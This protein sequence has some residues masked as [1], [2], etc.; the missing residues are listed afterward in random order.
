VKCFVRERLIA[1]RKF[2]FNEALPV[3]IRIFLLNKTKPILVDQSLFKQ[4]S[5]FSMKL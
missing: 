4:N 3:E 5:S 2:F 1:L